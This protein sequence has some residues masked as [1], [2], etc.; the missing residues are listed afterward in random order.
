MVVILH[1]LMVVD[2]NTEQEHPELYKT[3]C[4]QDNIILVP[5]DE[6]QVFLDMN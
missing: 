2:S 1:V 3:S 6:S 5:K 4:K